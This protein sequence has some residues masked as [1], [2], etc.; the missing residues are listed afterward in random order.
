MGVGLGLTFAHI[1]A[2]ESNDT[3]STV[4]AG[5]VELDLLHLLSRNLAVLAGLVLGGLL[6]GIPT[7]VSLFQNGFAIGNLAGVAVQDDELVQFLL[8]ILPH[9]IF[10]FP[11]LWLAGCLGLKIP[12]DIIQFVREK[13]ETPLTSRDISQ[14]LI[15]LLGT[16]LLVLL[17]AVVESTITATLA[18]SL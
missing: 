14:I 3:P 5:A 10:E 12:R 18:R 7:I 16:G 11:A 2:M 1:G 8:L 6:F 4:T 15:L 9:G 13:R 17:A